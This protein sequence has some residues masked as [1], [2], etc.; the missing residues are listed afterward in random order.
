MD[1]AAIGELLAQ[2]RREQKL[3][4]E[5]CSAETKIRERYLRA[6][7]AGDASAF[8]GAVYLKGFLK[9]YADF[10]GLDGKALVAE[11]AQHVRD[12]AEAEARAAGRRGQTRPARQPSGPAD[13]SGG[14]AAGAPPAAAEA[15]RPRETPPKVG[16]LVGSGPLAAGPTRRPGRSPALAIFLAAVLL[17]A[18]ALAWWAYVATA[19]VTDEL[20]RT[21]GPAGPP[22]AEEPAEEPPPESEEEPVEPSGT[23]PPVSITRTDVG[24][25]IQLSVSSRPLTVVLEA[26]WGRCWVYVT[27]DGAYRF[28]GTLE[29]GD[30]RRIE[31][32]GQVRIRMGNPGGVSVTVNGVDLGALSDGG[33]RDA[34]IT[35]AGP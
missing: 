8:P 34:I 23:A 33:P 18:G 19:P 3:A 4:L 15:A 12:L 29:L 9:N 22:A 16:A 25:T 17:G 28:E 11:Y 2:A 13:T 24:E 30:A 32:A 5:A 27:A 14:Y 1:L 20:P 7:E 35:A 21:P 10:L 26:R 6:L 31:A